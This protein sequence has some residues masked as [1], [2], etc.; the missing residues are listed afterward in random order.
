M[1][2]FPS[3]PSRSAPAL[4]RRLTAAGLTITVSELVA[5]LW[6]HWPYDAPAA[7]WT[8]CPGCG[9]E[10]ADAAP[11]CPTAAVARPLLH[12]RR[13]EATLTVAHRFAGVDLSRTVLDSHPGPR[14]PRQP[15][16]R[17]RTGCDFESAPTLFDL[18]C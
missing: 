14:T 4:D 1:T 6:D 8:R 13:H 2:I 15:D 12:R 7:S 18:A 5:I 11:D 16:R 3:D 17:V 9:H 10:Y